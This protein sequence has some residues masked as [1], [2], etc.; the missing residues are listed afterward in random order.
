MLYPYIKQYIIDPTV[1]AAKQ[2]IYEPTMAFLGK[3]FVENSTKVAS[4]I[5]TTVAAKHFLTDGE[6]H[7]E[8]IQP[9]QEQPELTM[10]QKAMTFAK[11][12]VYE[13]TTQAGLK[14]LNAILPVPAPMLYTAPRAIRVASAQTTADSRAFKAIAIGA[15]S[16][17]IGTFVQEQVDSYIPL[18]APYGGYVGYGIASGLTNVGLEKIANRLTRNTP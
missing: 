16:H 4:G 13:N 12:I 5:A 6:P 11:G 8:A 9:V 7:A 18:A 3:Q 17:G 14:V 10:K 15:A 1:E 2:Y